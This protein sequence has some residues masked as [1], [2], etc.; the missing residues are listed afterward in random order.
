MYQQRPQT[1]PAPYYQTISSHEDIIFLRQQVRSSA[2]ELGLTLLQQAKL[3]TAVG[4]MAEA[5]RQQCSQATWMVRVIT[6]RGRQTL[7]IACVVADKQRATSAAWN[8]VLPLTTVRYLVAETRVVD[9]LGRV[10]ISL[11]EP[12]PA[13]TQRPFK[14]PRMVGV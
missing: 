12:V 8:D 1:I 9:Q 7:D 4:T 13:A 14:S 10:M 5:V 11:R 6:D 2:R 3:T